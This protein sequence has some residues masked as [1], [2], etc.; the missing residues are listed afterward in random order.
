M[1]KDRGDQ[2]FPLYAREDFIARRM[3]KD[4]RVNDILL[5]C[6]GINWWVCWRAGI[7]SDFGKRSSMAMAC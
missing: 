1:R 2:F 6:T 5:A 7:R 4:L 3:F